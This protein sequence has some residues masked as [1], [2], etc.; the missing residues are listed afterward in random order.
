MIS[1]QKMLLN[2][3]TLTD[4]TPKDFIELY[5]GIDR[6]SY[7]F[8]IIFEEL[9]RRL[10]FGYVNSLAKIYNKEDLTE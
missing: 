9:T 3:I 8:P 10:S 2:G 5:E 7:L 1:V 4:L 6:D